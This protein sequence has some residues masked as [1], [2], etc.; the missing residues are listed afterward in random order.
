MLLAR[1]FLRIRLRRGLW[2]QRW[3]SSLSAPAS[4]S[5]FHL[6]TADDGLSALGSPARPS[7]PTCLRPA[8]PRVSDGEARE[9]REQGCRGEE[10]KKDEM[11]WI[12][13]AR[14]IYAR[15]VDVVAAA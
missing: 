3:P 13:S 2:I 9:G 5:S 8:K 4:L 11:E 12:Y 1:V 6:V 10:M 7:R 15:A 14:A